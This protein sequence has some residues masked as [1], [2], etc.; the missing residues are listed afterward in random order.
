MTNWLVF[1]ESESH[2]H[3]E[4]RDDNFFYTD[5]NHALERTLE[6]NCFV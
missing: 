1:I 5:F 4:Q 6:G 2:Y 3:L